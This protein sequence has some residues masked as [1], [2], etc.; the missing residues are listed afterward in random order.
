MKDDTAVLEAT[1]L[2]LDTFVSTPVAPDEL[3]LRLGHGNPFYPFS[4]VGHYGIF[5]ILTVG[6]NRW[7]IM[8]R[9]KVDLQLDFE[10]PSNTLGEINEAV[11]LMLESAPPGGIDSPTWKVKCIEVISREPRK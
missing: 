8:P 9:V 11:N 7:D 5:Y 10:Y 1:L 4:P 2:S 3:I 6:L